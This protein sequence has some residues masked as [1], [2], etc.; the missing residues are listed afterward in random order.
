M[1]SHEVQI[2]GHLRDV[3][4]A[5]NGSHFG[6]TITIFVYTILFYI[7]EWYMILKILFLGQK[8]ADPIKM[9]GLSSSFTI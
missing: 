6:A 8:S 3:V 7:S 9:G 1:V 2:I 4:S 5:V